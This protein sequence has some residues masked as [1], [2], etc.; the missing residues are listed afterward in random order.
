[1]GTRTSDHPPRVRAL[2]LAAPL[3]FVAVVAE[4]ERAQAP[5][6]HADLALVGARFSALLAVVVVGIAATPASAAL[7]AVPLSPGP[8]T[9]LSPMEAFEFR[10]E[11]GESFQSGYVVIGRSPDTSESGELE[12]IASV[13]TFTKAPFSRR[14]YRAQLG[15]ASA[16]R[17]EPGDWWWQ[18][19][20]M[21]HDDTGQSVLSYQPPRR[22]RVRPPVNRRGRLAP[23]FGR[24][25]SHRL[26]ISSVGIPPAVGPAR[27]GALVRSAARRWGIRVAGW[28]SR[29]AGTRDHV[30]V[31]GWGPG[32]RGRSHAM[33]RAALE[34]RSKRFRMCRVW[35]RGGQI[36][37]KECGALRRIDLGT[38]IV[39]RDVVLK[40]APYWYGGAAP[41][42]PDQLDLESVLLHEFGHFAGNH[43][44]RRRCANHPLMKSFEVG[45]WWR[46]SRDWYMRGCPLAD[47]FGVL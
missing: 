40:P 43:R 15:V 33:F 17:R 9:T 18:V 6:P 13:A 35:R 21:V 45:E 31:V 41:P 26:L 47:R 10:I 4:A 25:A 36:V 23:R 3:V 39:D 42:P 1:M 20:A 5:G 16:L 7:P 24:R 12:N 14:V 37:R 27:F 11:A 28:T 29:Q 38:T 34:R 8:S 46:G 2:A 32:V 19:V 30:N 44:H 22:L